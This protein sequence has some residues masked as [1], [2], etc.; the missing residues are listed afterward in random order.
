MLSVHI[1][2]V[3]TVILEWFLAWLLCCS[4]ISFTL[5]RHWWSIFWYH[6]SSSLLDDIP[7][8]EA[9]EAIAT[10]CSKGF[11]LQTSQAI[12]TGFLPSRFLPS[13]RDGTPWPENVVACCNGELGSSCKLLSKCIC[14]FWYDCCVI[15]GVFFFSL[16]Q[17][18]PICMFLRCSGCASFRVRFGC[19]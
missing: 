5:P 1:C 9:T 6:I 18:M 10:I 2:L 19:V 15:L 3:V 11:W 4:C 14:L 17:D 8:L 16:D 7:T 12:V 13:F